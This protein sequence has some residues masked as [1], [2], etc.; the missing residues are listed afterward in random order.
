MSAGPASWADQ[1]EAEDRAAQAQ[2]PRRGR[3]G[4]PPAP[5][6]APALVAAPRLRA[7]PAV[8]GMAVPPEPAW[9]AALAAEQ[10]RAGGLQGDELAQYLAAA[11]ERATVPQPFAKSHA[12]VGAHEECRRFLIGLSE[13]LV[14]FAKCRLT[15]LEEQKALVLLRSC[16]TGA[17]AETWY[18]AVTRAKATATTGPGMGSVLYRAFREMLTFYTD[19]NAHKTMAAQLEDLKYNDKG[20]ASTKVEWAK[21]MENYDQ[22]AALTEGLPMP[23]QLPALTWPAWFAMLKKRLPSWAQKVIIEHPEDF[24]SPQAFWDTLGRYEPARANESRPGVRALAPPHQGEPPWPAV[25]DGRDWRDAALEAYRAGNYE[26]G[27]ACLNAEKYDDADLMPPTPAHLHALA[28]GAQLLARNGRPINC[29]FCGENHR[30][31]DCP[32]PGAGDGAGGAAAGARAMGAPRLTR[33]SYAPPLVQRPGFGTTG[34]TF[35]APNIQASKDD[36]RASLLSLSAQV[37]AQGERFEQ[38]MAGFTAAQLQP[39]AAPL[40]SLPRLA[41]VLVAAHAPEGYVQ[42]GHSA[43]GGGAEAVPVWASEAALLESENV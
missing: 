30:V 7:G 6:P 18:A 35:V 27:D 37:Q 42:V 12:D 3:S 41:P 20:V 38:V 1:V 36:V 25:T 29:F 22:V 43:L 31:A 2:H 33:P 5:V 4:G 14:A 19:R 10:T 24:D 17:A 28:Q 39:A 26:L 23:L 32:H 34:P 11:R 9:L 21:L 8:A 15:G 16:F 40:L 13:M